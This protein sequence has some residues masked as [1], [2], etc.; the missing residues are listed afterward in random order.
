MY[1]N[2]HD[3]YNNFLKKSSI[4]SSG[5]NQLPSIIHSNL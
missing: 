4:P 5:F 2:I 3:T 1:L